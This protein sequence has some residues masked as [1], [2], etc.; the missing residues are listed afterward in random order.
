MKNYGKILRL[1]AAP[2]LLA[3]LSSCEKELDFDYHDVPPVRVIEA[4]LTGEGSDVLVTLTTPMDRPTDTTPLTDVSVQLT[5]LANGETR[6]LPRK[7]DGHFGDDIP[8][9]PGHEYRITVT[10]GNDTYSS[11]AMMRESVETPKLEFGLIDMAGDK[12]AVLQ[13]S[14]PA[15]SDD[16]ARYWI[17]LLRN[18][19]PYKWTIAYRQPDA[20]GTIR[21]VIMASPLDTEEEDENRILFDGDTVTAQ[22]LPVS[23]EM[24]D[25]LTAVESD[26]NGPA[27]WNGPLC[28]GY[29]L[30]APIAQ[31]SIIYHPGQLTAN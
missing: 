28:L 15:L 17:R 4:S 25:Y 12:T 31:A 2:L 16:A 24:S 21:S 20:T 13:V 29:F 6:L 1:L 26:S 22:V 7:P 8:G 30:P 18:G 3:A 9:I 10:V 19:E 27:M 14:F 11:A 23:R 5:D